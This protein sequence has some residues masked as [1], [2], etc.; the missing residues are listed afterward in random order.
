VKIDIKTIEKLASLSKLKFTKEE[1]DLISK[2]MS[3]MVDFINQL[4]EIDTE[5]VEPLIH[6]N[7]GFN[8]WREDEIREMLDQKEALSNSPIKDSTYFKL[9]KVLDK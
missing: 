2:D 6:V 9:P 1:L 3:K 4:D 5:G 7:E 8:N